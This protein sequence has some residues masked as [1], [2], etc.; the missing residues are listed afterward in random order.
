[1]KTLIVGLAVI[2]LNTLGCKK[3]EV[4]DT[5]PTCIT[6]NIE[7][8]KDKTDWGIRSIDEYQYQGMVVYVY[9]P[10]ANYADAQVAVIKTDCT[11]LC[12]LGGFTGNKMCN[13]DKFYDKAVYV[14]TV[15]Q[16]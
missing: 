14:K 13:G 3:E 1:M 2:A 12:S 6:N 11:S 15:W 8:N 16:K 5:V 10:D 4:D 9:N 7:A